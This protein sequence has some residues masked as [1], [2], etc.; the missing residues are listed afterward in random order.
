MAATALVG[1]LSVYKL[2]AYKCTSTDGICQANNVKTQ[3]N[4]KLVRVTHSRLRTPY[5][6]PHRVTL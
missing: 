6:K 3:N 4:N 5:M 1:L 2:R